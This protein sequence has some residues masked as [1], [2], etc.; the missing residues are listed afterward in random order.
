MTDAQRKTKTDKE[1][2]QTG[3]QTSRPKGPSCLG[4]DRQEDKT[5]C[6]DIPTY[7]DQMKREY[8]RHF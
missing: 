3:K 4:I 2:T 8:P 7:R 1:D 5:K 6:R